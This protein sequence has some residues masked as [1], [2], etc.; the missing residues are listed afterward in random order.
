M[1]RIFILSMTIISIVGLLAIRPALADGAA[2]FSNRSLS[3]AFGCRLSGL[4]LADPNNPPGLPTAAVIREAFDGKGKLS[5]SEV[6][7]VIGVVCHWTFANGTYQIDKTGVGTTA[8]NL[9]PA[10]TDSPACG[11]T[12]GIPDSQA[13]VIGNQGVPFSIFEVSAL[14]GDCTPQ[15]ASF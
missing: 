14:S 15:A 12:S 6:I 1:K 7:Q 2:Q 3:G 11:P 13:F 9:V 10:P 5:G 8:F 4:L